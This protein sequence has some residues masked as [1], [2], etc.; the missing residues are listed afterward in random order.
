MAANIRIKRS[1]TS[2][3]PT[4]LAQGELAYSFLVDNGSNGG[5]RLYVGTGTEISGDAAN[6]TVIGGKYYV[7]LLG[8]QG[9]ASFGTLTASQAII[10]DSDKRI[11]EL[12][13]D[14]IKLDGNTLSTTS[15]N[16][17]LNPFGYVDLSSNLI[18]NLASPVDSADAVN[19]DY[20]D[21]QLLSSVNFTISDGVATDTFNAAT[22]TLTF[23][24]GTGITTAVTD[25]EIT[26]SIT[27][28]GVAADVYGSATEIPVLTINAQG[29]ITVASTASVATDLTFNGD[30]ISLLDSDLSIVEGEGID[31]VY[32]SA[33]NILT[34]SGE[35]ATT[36]NKGIASFSTDN[37]DVTAGAVSIKD[38][39]ISN[40]ELIN[41]FIK[42]GGDS[43][44]LGNTITDIAGL[45][46]LVIDNIYIDGNI[47]G[48]NAGTLFLDPGPVGDSGDVVI[49]GNL[50]VQGTTTTINST[51]VTINDANIVLA[52][53]ATSA[54]EADGAGITVNGANATFTYD[55][56]TD[57]WETNKGLN[58]GGELLINNIPFSDAVD[59]SVADLLLAGQSIDLT[60][61]VGAGTL[62]IAAELATTANIGV[63]SFD[64]D[65]FTVTTGLVSI[66]NIDGGIY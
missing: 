55:A 25:D 28:T 10:V 40:A 19:K 9:G 47:V 63:A 60:Y 12:F 29:Q 45:T 16:L 64:S 20:V 18:K 33:T 35:D 2:G 44:S 15:G 56:P 13:I 36:T 50:T 21:S 38:G 3:N 7:D 26:F 54:I 65:Q 52:D 48:T 23:T 31:V 66:Y 41:S 51:T 4:T 37:F 49:L 39:G 58:V 62:T 34:I 8:G 17:T 42:I 6:H 46:S 32:D 61:D 1:G 22:G 11:N 43:V 53:S 30:T 57:R 24:G 27:N 59:S 14:N 5:D